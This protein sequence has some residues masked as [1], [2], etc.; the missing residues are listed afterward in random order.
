SLACRCAAPM[1]SNGR[2][3]EC[4]KKF[5]ALIFSGSPCRNVKLTDM[6]ASGRYIFPGT[7]MDCL[8]MILGF[9]IHCATRNAVRCPRRRALAPDRRIRFRQRHRPADGGLPRALAL[10]LAGRA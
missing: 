5:G 6:H 8:P 4:R 3:A 7:F 1:W 9:V 10:L 2:A